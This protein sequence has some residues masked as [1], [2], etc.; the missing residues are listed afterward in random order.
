MIFYQKKLAVVIVSKNQFT[1]YRPVSQG[2]IED[3]LRAGL[4]SYTERF[5]LYIVDMFN[6]HVDVLYL[7]MINFLT[8]K[9]IEPFLGEFLALFPPLIFPFTGD[10]EFLDFSRVNVLQRRNG[11]SS[12]LHSRS[13]LNLTEISGFFSKLLMQISPIFLRS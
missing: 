13:L 1:P 5:E 2:V 12:G 7:L 6:V 9:F 3:F 8:L 10:F 4:K 11:C